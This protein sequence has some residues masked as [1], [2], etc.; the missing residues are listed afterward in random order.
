MNPIKT[1]IIIPSYN[2]IG[3]LQECIASIRQYTAVPYEIIVVDNGSTDG[4]VN[5]C[6]QERIRLVSL[7]RNK[8]FPAACN[9]GLKI[10]TGDA[11]LLLN[12]DTVVTHNWLSNMLACLYSGERI[13]I[14]GPYTN[15]VIGMQK[16][17]P[18]YTDLNQFHEMAAISNK[19]NPALWVPINRVIGL[20]LLFKREVM[21]KIGLLDERFT[22]GHYED[23]DFSYRA[24][25]A[26]YQ[27]ML[28]GDV[29]I[30]HHGAASFNK[31]ERKQ[32]SKWVLASRKKFIEKWNIEPI[33]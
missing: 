29:T 3:L 2:E 24:T 22:P 33:I 31:L 30:H 26:G 10:A 25:L 14:V 9:L 7:P 12:N 19:P 17:E 11:S 23:D 6:L 32:L 18:A 16:K 4:T 8:G 13:G 27:L 20:C 5:Y 15:Y 21:N 1:S 28:A